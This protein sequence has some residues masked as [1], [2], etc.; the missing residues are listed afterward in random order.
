MK[1]VFCTGNHMEMK[2]MKW[3]NQVIKKWWCK[4]ND[5]KELWQ[6]ELTSQLVWGWYWFKK[7]RWLIET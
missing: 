5:V 7:Y 4:M 1:C 6:N 3:K 2:E